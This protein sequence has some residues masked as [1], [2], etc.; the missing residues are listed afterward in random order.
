MV[1]KMFL[2]SIGAIIIALP[3]LFSH[4][5]SSFTGT[6]DRANETINQ[7]NSEYKPWFNITNN[8]FSKFDE[9]TMFSV[10]AALGVGFITYFIVKKKNV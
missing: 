8:P 6:D 5:L 3:I 7:I 2:I 1:K 10:Q 9:S 4:G